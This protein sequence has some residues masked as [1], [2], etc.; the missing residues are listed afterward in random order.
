MKTP[1]LYL[2]ELGYEKQ[3]F[4]RFTP[5]RRPPP[6]LS[7]WLPREVIYSQEQGRLPKVYDLGKLCILLF[8]GMREEHWKLTHTDNML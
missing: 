2:T 4:S 7:P 5:S 3:D 1:K 8:L 6:S